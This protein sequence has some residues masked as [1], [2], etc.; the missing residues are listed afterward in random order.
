MANYNCDDLIVLDA[1]YQGHH[2]P[3]VLDSPFVKPAEMAMHFDAIFGN[4]ARQMAEESV[5]FRGCA[6]RFLLDTLCL[7]TFGLPVDLFWNMFDKGTI[8]RLQLSHFRVHPEFWAYLDHKTQLQELSFVDSDLLPS[9]LLRFLSCQSNLQTLTFT[10]PLPK[11]VTSG[12]V[13]VDDGLF[14]GVESVCKKSDRFTPRMLRDLRSIVQHMPSFTRL[15]LPEFK[16]ENDE[17]SGEAEDQDLPD[18]GGGGGGVWE[19]KA[20]R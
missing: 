15:V 17:E 4:E 10:E 13:R 19:L 7:K 9:E 3:L 12:L 18:E 11:F 14:M 6:L 2:A 5:G 20:G 16:S 1:K 8:H